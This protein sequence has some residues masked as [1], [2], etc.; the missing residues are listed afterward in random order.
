LFG[1]GTP[2]NWILLLE[3]NQH[4]MYKEV[5]DCVSVTRRLCICDEKDVDV[6][7]FLMVE[8]L[9]KESKDVVEDLFHCCLE[10]AW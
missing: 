7:C 9:W 2:I 3:S 8:K 4:G 5:D 6:V 10:R 1:E